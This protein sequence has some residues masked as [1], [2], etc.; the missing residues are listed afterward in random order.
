MAVPGLSDC[1]HLSCPRRAVL[2]IIIRNTDGKNSADYQQCLHGEKSFPDGTD[3]IT[4]HL[5]E[6]NLRSDA[7][8]HASRATSRLIP[9]AWLHRARTMSQKPEDLSRPIVKSYS[10]SKWVFWIND[11]LESL[12]SSAVMVNAKIM[13]YPLP[14]IRMLTRAS[15]CIMVS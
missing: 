15:G 12:A 10:M 1:S 9:S 11:S 8:R 13:S 2:V 3:S 14:M 6:K 7:F 4:L 5:P